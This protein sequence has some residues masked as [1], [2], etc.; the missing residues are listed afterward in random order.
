[1]TFWDNAS[2]V[3]L[4]GFTAARYAAAA[5]FLT[6]SGSGVGLGVGGAVGPRVWLGT[7]V[8][9]GMRSLVA[10]LTPQQRLAPLPS[11]SVGSRPLA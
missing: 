5:A 9:D 4:K 10:V 3:L 8:S 1:M 6:A 7:V 2:P 11:S